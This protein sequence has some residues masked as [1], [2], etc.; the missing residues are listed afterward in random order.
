MKNWQYLGHLLRYRPWVWVLT[1]L[2]YVLLYS[3]N[4]APP[5]IAQAIFNQLT[6]EA[7]LRLGLWTLVILWFGSTVA[8]QA[9]YCALMAGQVLY[10]H[11]I[12]ALIHANLLERLLQRSGVSTTAASSG[13]ILSRF[14]D[15]LQPIH[16]FLSSV[17]NLV[18][19]GVFAIVAISTMIRI[20]LLL[21]AVVFIPLVVITI[22]INQSRNRIIRFRETNQQA[23]AGVAGALG[24]LFGAV[25]AIKVAGAERPVL[26]NL[27][28]LNQVRQQAAV[29]D[30]MVGELLSAVGSNLA[31]IGTAILLLLMGQAMRT[32]NFTVGDFALFLYVVPFVA[33]NVGSV[34]WALTSYRQLGVSWARLT[35]L[36]EEAP[37]ATLVRHRPV[38]LH[39]NPPAL[40]PLV[41]TTADQLTLLEV[42]GLTYHYPSTGGGIEQVSLHLPRGS[43]T[44]I[45]GRIGSGKTTLLRVLLGLLPKNGGEVRWNGQPVDAPSVFFTPPRSAYTPQ[46][47]RLFSDSLRENILMG[48]VVE[49]SELQAALHAAVLEPDI[50]TL[51][52]GLETVIGARGVK[53]SGGQVQRTAAARMFARSGPQGADLLVFDDLSSALDVETEQQLWARLFVRRVSGNAPTCLVVSHRHAALSRADQIIV[54]KDGRVEASGDLPTL[55]ESSMELRSL[56]DEGMRR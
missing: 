55:L 17:F 36:L 8:R 30:Q 26:A 48:A 12:G 40:P 20:N 47:P 23:T 45:T 44:V 19:V 5:L 28:R 6:G 2:A 42:E 15:D 54:L 21:T 50:V 10:F 39:N 51:E 11:T 3:L 52:Q 41:K 43:F 56:W 53:L 32:G 27:Q 49:E 38:Y 22:V 18:G 34:A 31:D 24:E 37:P 9:A 25:Q 13:E 16:N 29:K 46:A 1:V 35:A 33:G 14:R 7:P 4:F